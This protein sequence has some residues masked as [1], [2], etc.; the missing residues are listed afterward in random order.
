MPP[1]EFSV[2]G[3]LEVRAGDAAVEI[4]RG[5]PRTLL[6]SLVLRAGEVVTVDTLIDNLWGDD[7]PANP[8]NALQT[9][10]SYLRKAL[11]AADAEGRD[12]LQ[13]RPGGYLLA[14]TPDEVDARRF[15]RIVTEARRLADSGTSA[16]LAAALERFDDALGLW[17]GEPLA[18]AALE[19]F[20]TGE[21]T[22]LQELR[23]HAVE[24]RIDA[25]LLLGRHHE[26]IDELAQ[27]V[28]D[29][30]LRERFHEQRMLA[31]YRA[32]RQAEALRAFEA[33]RHHLAEELGLEPGP[34]LRALESQVLAQSDD[35]AW[36]PPPG[37]D[38]GAALAPADTA[39]SRPAASSLPVPLTP[40]IGR[41]LEADRLE[42]VLGRSRL[43]TITGPGGAGKSR[44]ALELAH[45]T[46]A[47]RPAWF[48]DLSSVRDGDDV[49]LAVAATLGVPTPPDQDPLELVGAALADREGLLLLDT[50][51]HVVEAVAATV[52]SLLRR[53]PR[54]RVLATSRRSLGVGGEVAWP[55]PPMSMPAS[56]AVDVDR[57]SAHDAVQLFC[58]RARAARPSFELD[59]A[60]VAD[61]VAI[62]AAVDGL[63]LG[64]ELAAAHTDVLTPASIRA[65]LA[66]R[67]RL[68]VGGDRDAAARQQTL[69]A[70]FDWSL[71]L[72]DGPE[73]EVFTRLG[74]FAGSFD[75]DAVVAVV[76]D[77][78]A[79]PLRLLANLVRQSM[80]V[81]TGDDRFRLLDSLRDY[82]TEL[83]VADGLVDATAA[84]HATWFL[85][86][87][88]AADVKVRSDEQDVWLRRLHGDLPNLRAAL[89][90][91]F[92]H[93]PHL[94]ARLATSLAWFFT[95]EGMLG[96]ADRWLDRALA[97]EDLPPLD[98]CGALTASA[99]LAAPLGRLERARDACDEAA[100]IAR[101]LD[102]PW[103]VGNALI[104][105]GVARWA[106]DDFEGAVRD[107]REA[108]ESFT[109]AG[110]EWGASVTRVLLARTAID[111]G[112]DAADELLAAALPAARAIGDR[113][114][115][116]LV[117]EQQARLAIRRGDVPAALAAASECLVLHESVGSPEGTASA[118]HVLGVAR[119]LA[120][121][122]DAAESVH[123]RALDLAVTIRHAAATAEA[124]EDL[125]V[126]AV[127]AG[128]LDRALLLVRTAV[129][130]REATGVPVRRPDRGRI[131]ELLAAVRTAHGDA[132]L[133]GGPRAAAV[134][135]GLLHP[136]A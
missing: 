87:A 33:A 84:R 26:A 104:T 54:L 27:L 15:E 7:L 4:R 134:V 88:E 40:L 93:D 109:R 6:L 64:I 106:L 47:G 13:T 121:D 18:D 61:V 51:E 66:D 136:G 35:L 124:L 75:L 133:A 105:G 62:C 30:P 127:D 96:E 125:A 52:A 34:S 70:A 113:H 74:V 83:L 123:L 5:H 53:S 90:W 79:D 58:A 67:F 60:N 99:F 82:A 85:S 10:V 2:L 131:E 11:A 98:R 46:S 102:E 16:A 9:Q 48:V 50:C 72:L 86:L 32:G 71:A 122:A 135:D 44:L 116:A 63:P 42:E 110:N 114:I 119:R 22:R 120:G 38:A 126:L 20:A 92:A 68:L 76:G 56:D 37:H 17:R 128:D 55:L 117:A 24:H 111:S 12:V 49:P 3:P 31:L 1:V 89:D 112:D 130:E 77:D 29:H 91:S 69:R 118:L 43:V 81:A 57:A 19:P 94:G 41:D 132:A 101:E 107:H 14:A 65:R 80:V 8:A 23:L 25:L 108:L 28:R 59:D 45:R 95:L 103:H 115:L 129:A 39:F 97:I 36:T 21:A 73:R 78:Y 100:A